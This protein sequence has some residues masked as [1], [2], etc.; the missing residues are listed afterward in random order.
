MNDET[1]RGDTIKVGNITNAQGVAAGR[2]ASATVTGDNIS[3]TAT[4]D[5]KELRTA[6]ER[7]YDAIGEAQIPREHARNAQTAAGNAIAG[8]NQK[9]VKPDV[10][11]ESVKKIGETIKQA[12]VAVQEGTSLWHSVQNLASLVGPLVGGARVVASWFGIP[13]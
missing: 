6:L 9:E 1:R 3:G 8:T 2:G 11:V 12:D 13:S 5:A 4:L 7:L 10:V